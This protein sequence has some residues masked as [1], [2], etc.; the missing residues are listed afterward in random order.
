[1]TAPEKIYLATT[2]EVQNLDH[3]FMGIAH[4][5]PQDIIEPVEYIRTDTFIKKAVN[6]IANNMRC[7]NGYT[8]QTKIKFIKDFI[9]YIE[10]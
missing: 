8:L 2:E 7:N 5:D 1:M 3:S 9:K 6:Y 4:S 10:K